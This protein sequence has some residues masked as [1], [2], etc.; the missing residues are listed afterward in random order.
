MNVDSVMSA[1]VSTPVQE[2]HSFT[3]P[4]WIRSG[5]DEQEGKVE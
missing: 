4:A 2:H 1:G 3:A 5:F